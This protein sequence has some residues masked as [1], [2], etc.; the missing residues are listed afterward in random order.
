MT[1]TLANGGTRVHAAPASRR[2]TTGR[3][4]ARAGAGAAVERRGDS[5]RSCRRSAT[6]CG[7]SS[8]A[9]G[10]GGRARDRGQGRLGQDRHGAGHLADR[11]PSAGARPGW[12]CATTAGSSF[13]RRATTRRSPASCS[14]STG[15]TARTPRR[16]RSTSI[17]TYFAKQG[18]P[19]PPAAAPRPSRW[20]AARRSRIV[21][22]PEPAPVPAATRGGGN[23]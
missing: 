9:A 17:E 4:E 23:P 11:A 8:T 1:T 6:A 16:S 20:R 22:G 7:W 13:L 14:S 21:P 12:T 5:R 15:S 2:S 18:G 19:M 10:T 3:A